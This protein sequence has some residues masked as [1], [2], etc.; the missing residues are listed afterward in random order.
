MNQAHLAKIVDRSE[1]FVILHGDCLDSG[2][3]EPLH[4][5]LIGAPADFGGEDIRIAHNDSVARTFEMFFKIL[6]L[7]SSAQFSKSIV[8]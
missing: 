5:L 6:V 8:G 2:I 3:C 4:K 7:Q 1:Q